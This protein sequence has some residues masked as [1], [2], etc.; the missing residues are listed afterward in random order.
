MPRQRPFLANNVLDLIGYT[1]LVRIN[2]MT[3]Q[4]SA[5]V[6]LKLEY[7]NPMFSVKDRI[8]FA[9]LRR[10]E[11]EGKIQP[12]KTVI[13]EPTSGNTGIGLAMAAAVMGYRLILTMPDTMS[14]ERRRILA[15]MGAE[16]VLTPE[17]QGMTAAIQKA[18]ELLKQHPDSFMP[19]QF[20]NPANPEIHRKTTAVEI[21]EATE[22]RLDCFVAGVGTGG[23]ITGVGEVL[24]KELPKV[25]IVGIEPADS[26]VLSGG[27]PGPHQIQGIGAGFVPRVLN[28][29]IIDE[30]ICVEYSDA[31]ET[32]RSLAR[33][34]GIFAGI[35]SGAICWA[36]LQVARKLG[37]GQRL[38]AVMP[39]SGER[40]LSHDVYA[41]I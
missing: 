10:A 24:K 11:D 37:P 16:L 28:R 25:L 2:R 15:A 9:M 27:N 26:P 13:I 20:N 8:A 5:E 17:I 35:S 30:V 21:L 19:Q 41:D 23:T 3:A 12:G 34:E 7:L 36:A 39:D 32:A 38:V 22:G 33:K 6:L 4:S 29:K 40:Y 31:R 14:L 1:P 18:E